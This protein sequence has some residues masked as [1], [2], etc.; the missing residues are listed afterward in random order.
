[1]L[2]RTSLFNQ[3]KKYGAI[4]GEFGGYEMPLWLKNGAKKEH[5]AVLLSAGIFDTS[6][7]STLLI[8]GEKSRE[9]LQCLTAKDLNR[10][11]GKEKK[12]LS[13]NQSVYSVYLDENGY[14]ID[15]TIIFQ[16]DNNRY[17]SVVNASMGEKIIQHI[18][19]F[20][21]DNIEII[22]YTDKIGK[23]DLQGILS[24]KALYNLLKEPSFICDMK[25]FTFRGSFNEN[26][27]NGDKVLTK[28]GYPI[29]VS[30]T[31]YTGEI[32]FEIFVDS[33][34]VEDL[35][36]SLLNNTNLEVLPCGLAARDSLRTG[37][38]LPLSHQDIGNW[39][40]LNNPWTFVLPFNDDKKTFTK[41]FLGDD[42][43]LKN[44]GF[45][46]Y[47]Y[48]FLGFDLRK[49]P[50]NGGSI[51]L[52]NNGEQI[53]VTLTC[54]TEPSIDR[55]N[56]RIYCIND[57]QK[58]EN[59]NIRGLSCGFVKVKKIMKLGDKI[60]LSDG[61]RTIDVEIVNALRPNLTARKAITNFL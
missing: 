20:N 48:P 15:D 42:A 16:L 4:F 14:V 17:I 18:N 36:E 31:G 47:T 39:P 59:L 13:N 32:G 10:T 19:K 61:K 9:L 33:K 6:H 51:V 55:Y 46:E 49:V 56:D 40:F 21:N 58:P 8:K 27:S 53:G 24:V 3:H 12:P 26:T 52:D 54:V 28:M 50:S 43:L 35:W 38:M 57:S 25:Y 60:K 34:Y 37:A 29:L 7:M 45:G 11:T 41:K 44:I 30:R 2:K 5:F 22:D 1:M 23:I